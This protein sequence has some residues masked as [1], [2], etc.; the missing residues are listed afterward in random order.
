[1]KEQKK[2]NR[3]FLINQVWLVKNV[4][5]FLYLSALAVIYIYNGHHAEKAIKDINK[6]S[7]ELKDLQ[8]EYKMVKSEWMFMT[9][10]SEVIKAVTPFGIKEILEPPVLINDTIVDKNVKRN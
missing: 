2:V 8:Y 4:P 5:F 6:T 1:M 7:K 3:W 9:K 10:Q